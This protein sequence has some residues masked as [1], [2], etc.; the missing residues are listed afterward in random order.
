MYSRKIIQG[1][2]ATLEGQGT[3]L[4]YYKSD[5]ISQII[6]HLDELSVYDDK[7][8]F[9]TFYR[10]LAKDEEAFIRNERILCG[11]D[12]HHWVT[13]YHYLRDSL[14]LQMI[15]YSPNLAQRIA[16]LAHGE[17][18]ENFKPILTQDLKARQLGRTSDT[19]SKILHRMLFIPN[20]SGLIAS[21]DP[22][23]SW[24]LS[25]M[26]SR[27][28][29]KQPHW[30]MPRD[31]K[32]YASGETFLDCPSR[33]SSI[34]IQHGTQQS[35]ISRGDTVNIFH[36]SEI[37]DWSD[38]EQLIVASLFNAMHVTNLTFGVM[39]ST[40][41]GRHDW[42]HKRWER[43]KEL[44]PKGLTL[45][46]PL[47]LPWFLGTEIYPTQAWLSSIPIPNGWEP[48]P[49]I[50]DHATKAREYVLATPLLRQVLGLDWR[51]PL[52]QMWWYYVKYE[53]HKRDG[54]L[55]DFFSETPANDREA[56]QTRSNSVFSVELINS[57][58]TKAKPPLGIFALQGAEIP[59]I[60]QPE[61]QEIKSQGML[62]PIRHI[63]HG[64]M[65]GGEL[66]W[67]LIEVVKELPKALH[68]LTIWELP[69]RG[70][71]YS[72]A[73]DGAEGIQKDRTVLPV[74]KRGTPE[75]PAEQ[76]AELA[77]DQV[78]T[79]EIWPVW[80]ALLN[81]YSPTSPS[82]YNW[83]MAA[84]EINRGGDAALM[85]IRKRGWT[86][87]YLRKIADDYR[88]Q[89]TPKLGWL[90]SSVTRDKLIQWLQMVI[91]GHFV[92][93]NSQ[94]T[95]DELRDFV[96]TELQSKI[97]L[98]AGVGA[99]DDRIFAFIIGVLC[100]HDVD[101]YR[102]E[103]PGWRSIRD[104]ERDL[105]EFADFASSNPY[106]FPGDPGGLRKRGR[107]VYSATS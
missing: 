107:V 29:I 58:E 9:K 91:K 25:E 47:F 78:S 63:P 2:L 57:Y 96:A 62:I 89:V 46:R 40:A 19:I 94:A 11:I 5:Y 23:K 93:L 69:Q 45:E 71:Q 56:F 20:T 68:R 65:E 88:R 77:T 95:I 86:N 51:L 8:R 83:A 44:Y 105:T 52:H 13:N 82:G 4:T 73:L 80:L 35:G 33:N 6:E 41:N 26:A 104:E 66:A 10:P 67:N 75:R 43:N 55:S 92:Q 30:L 74:I 60:L 12:Y 53:E 99:H 84:P 106:R 49:L 28:L 100:L 59:S 38:P 27:S 39:E 17:T 103:S 1:K 16:N 101:I 50:Q 31:L 64:R 21:S 3:S 14:S 15:K 48:P 34:T 36:I 37:P 61:T 24:K 72:V 90:T 81:L 102:S 98:E 85:E 54:T 32:E 18:E 22:E 42:W 70:E 76:V 79:L 97:R 87:I 7:G